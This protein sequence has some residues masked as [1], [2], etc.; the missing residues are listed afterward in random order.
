MRAPVLFPVGRP[1]GRLRLAASLP[2]DVRS[3]WSAE[4][5]ERTMT[6]LIGRSLKVME[7]LLERCFFVGVALQAA[8]GAP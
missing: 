4:E 2:S 8:R 7:A 6:M 3:A 5:A 1:S